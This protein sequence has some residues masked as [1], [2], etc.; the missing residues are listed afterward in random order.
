MNR[1]KWKNLLII[2]LI[3][4]VLCGCTTEKPN[5]VSGDN[6]ENQEMG[7]ETEKKELISV[8]DFRSNYGL[9]EADASDDFI[10]RYIDHYSLT[11]AKIE[12]DTFCGKDAKKEYAAGTVYGYTLTARAN[13]SVQVKDVAL[14]EFILK[15]EYIFI[16][17]YRTMSQS[18][19][20]TKELMS[21]DFKHMKIFF[22]GNRDNYSDAE[23]VLSADLTQ[24]DKNEICSE[25]LKHVNMNASADRE[26]KAK[27]YAFDLYLFSNDNELVFL[28]GS[29]LDSEAFPEFDAY[30]KGLYKKY[31]GKEYSFPYN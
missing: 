28:R 15:D 26:K 13:T 12:G 17:F 10:E 7:M 9:S 3:L 31:F 19:A 16:E 18:D 1:L 27:D 14:D 24:E 21:I 2:P 11:K 6:E 23:G 5:N 22:G 8:A 20:N 25:I 30:W 4:V 29:D